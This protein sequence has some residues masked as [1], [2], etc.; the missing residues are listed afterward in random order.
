MK[1]EFKMIA[2]LTA[3]ALASGGILAYTYVS[4]IDS[5]EKNN[6]EA[7]K[8]AVAKVLPGV[9]EYKEVKIDKHTSYFIGRKDGEVIGYAVLTEGSGFQGMIK[10][11]VGFDRDVTKITGLEILENVET[12]G[13]GNRITEDWFKEQFKDRMPELC[14]V[15]GRKPENE[16]E[17]MAI[18]G[19]T[20]SSKAVT[21]IVNQAFEKLKKALGGEE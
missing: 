21:K 5:I 12:P 3:I 20:I 6:E 10:L 9:Q 13:L 14:V 15:K 17:I 1:L 7:K 16:H 8:R 11:M 2:V 19:A 18:T 4:A